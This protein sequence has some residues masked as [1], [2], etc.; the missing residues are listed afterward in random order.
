MYPSIL[1]QTVQSMC[2][3]L[4]SICEVHISICKNQQ[5]SSVQSRNVS[6]HTNMIISILFL[7]VLYLCTL[8]FTYVH[9]LPRNRDW[10]KFDLLYWGTGLRAI[11]TSATW[12]GRQLAGTPASLLP[13]LPLG[14]LP[15]SCRSPPDAQL[16]QISLPS[17]GAR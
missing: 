15:G 3:F 8:L 9:S 10:W 4:L 7:K 11:S 5:F 6:V 12:T 1:I 14:T 13:V 17:F 16:R 2:N